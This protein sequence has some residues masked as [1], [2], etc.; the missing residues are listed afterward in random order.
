MV[1]AA[2]SLSLSFSLSSSFLLEHRA[3]AP[4]LPG[5]Q[6]CPAQSENPMIRSGV[7]SHAQSKQCV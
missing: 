5:A 2:V 6:T 1:Q 7:N 3:G 4:A